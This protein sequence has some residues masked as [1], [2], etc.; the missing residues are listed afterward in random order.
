MNHIVQEEYDHEDKTPKEWVLYS[1][2]SPILLIMK[3]Y[4]SKVICNSV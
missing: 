4:M 3:N 2:Q 1:K